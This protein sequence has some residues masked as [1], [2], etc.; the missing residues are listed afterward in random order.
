MSN[1]HRKKLATTVL[2]YFYLTGCGGSSGADGNDGEN[3]DSSAQIEPVN[4][5]QVETGNVQN[6]PDNNSPAEIETESTNNLPV[7]SDG[8]QTVVPLVAGFYTIRARE[9]E[10]VC[11]GGPPLYDLYGPTADNV[12]VTQSNKSIEIEYENY[13]TLAGT[14]DNDGIFEARGTAP[15]IG[16]I[17]QTFN[18]TGVIEDNGFWS[19]QL[20]V[21]LTAPFNYI[22]T[23]NPFFDGQRGELITE[24]TAPTTPTPTPGECIDTVPLNDGFGWNGVE[25][26]TLPVVTQPTMTPTPFVDRN[27]S[28]FSTQNEAQVFLE[29][30][31]TND[32]HVLDLDNDGLA[33][34]CNVGGGGWAWCPVETPT[35]TPF[36]DRNCSD[37]ATQAEAQA[38]FESEGGPSEDPHGLD[39]DGDGR[40][41][42]SLP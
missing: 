5:M 1:T 19:G 36:V 9:S 28:D 23:A 26:C 16:E 32:P 6:E 20:T 2:L 41:C 13:V 33:C 21:T 14:I 31:G 40:V 29:N 38:F 30:N 24:P 11:T 27:C 42:V 4:T 12:I 7:Q 3:Q 15:Q 17:T 37:F 18:L 39:G 10:Y 34:E 25:S 35:P 22:C 8:V